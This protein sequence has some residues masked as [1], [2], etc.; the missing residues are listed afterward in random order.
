MQ[1]RSGLITPLMEWHRRGLFSNEEEFQGALTFAH[2]QWLDGFGRVS[3]AHWVGREEGKSW[4]SIED[5]PHNGYVAVNKCW[6]IGLF[7]TTDHYIG[8][9]KL[10]LAQFEEG[11]MEGCKL[12]NWL[13]MNVFELQALRDQG[14]LPCSEK[15][16]KSIDPCKC[17]HKR[18]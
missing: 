17:R 3:E 18:K 9:L 15:D 10:A 5:Y 14:M 6:R 1:K 4:A 16:H 12:H 8:A 11:L 7:D 13:G 2:T